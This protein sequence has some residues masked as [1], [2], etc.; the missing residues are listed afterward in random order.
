M[1]KI[2]IDAYYKE[3]CAKVVGVIFQEFSDEKPLDI[4]SIEIN[5]LEEYESGQFYKRELP[6]ILKLLE[7][8]NQNE[9]DT[10][11]LDSHT[12]LWEKDSKAPKPGLGAHLY[13]WLE[14]KKNKHTGCS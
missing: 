12:W 5:N 14:N 13:G 9:F 1:K 4:I 6:G 2:A 10:I 3:T 7:K 11:L 8:I